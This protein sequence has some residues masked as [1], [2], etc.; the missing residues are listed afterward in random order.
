MYYT[1][2]GYGILLDMARELKE[3]IY[4]AR[5]R[6]KRDTLWIS[7][8]WRSPRNS[9]NIYQRPIDLD[10]SIDWSMF[11]GIALDIQSSKSRW[12]ISTMISYQPIL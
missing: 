5:K 12:A 2:A 6:H 9:S 1:L 7:S 3:L 10:Y 8:Q 4:K 11:L